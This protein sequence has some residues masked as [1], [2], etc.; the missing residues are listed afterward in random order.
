MKDKS[1]FV[2]N[3]NPEP[4]AVG[5]LALGRRNGKMIPM[6][7]RNESVHSFKEAVKGELEGVK[8]LAKGE[9]HLEF[10]LWR[11]LESY[12]SESGRIASANIADATNMQKALEDALQGVLFDNDRHV[13][14]IT[15]MVVDQGTLVTPCIIIHATPWIMTEDMLREIIPPNVL[16]T[17]NNLVAAPDVASDNTWPPS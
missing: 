8:P 3:V 6:M 11:R 4:W 1:W 12:V 7:Q 16:H 13:R 2:L 10:F 9:Y 17:K 15:T 5:P 14:E